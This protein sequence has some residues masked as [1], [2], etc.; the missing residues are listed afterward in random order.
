[1]NVS[2]RGEEGIISKVITNGEGVPIA[3]TAKVCQSGSHKRSGTGV[4]LWRSVTLIFAIVWLAIVIVPVYYMVLT[5]LRSQGTYLT[6]DPW[7]PSGHLSLHE[8]FVVLRAGL[9]RYFLNSVLVTAGAIILTVAVGLG[10][11]FRIV[12]SRS[13]AGRRSFTLLLLGLAVPL[14]AAVV[15]LYLL[16]DKLGL[17]NTL[18]ALILA[19]AAAAL[20]V[21][22][23]IL[24]SFIR[25]IPRETIAAME[26]DGGSEGTVFR[27][28][29]IPLSLP[30]LG[31][32][33]IYDGINVWNNFLL[34][35]ILTQGGNVGVLPLGLYKFEG[36]YTI[37]VP[38]VMAA[39]LLSVLPL[40]LLYLVLRRQVVRSLSGLGGIVQR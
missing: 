1:M 22:V 34:P 35:L 37:D 32:V 16:I 18:W 33:S 10:G 36:T 23:L 17:Y 5:S 6:A 24:V 14:Q 28:L 26:V 12:R 27:Y 4:S 9:G 8:Y 19:M 29:I 2:A 21:S 13:S 11:A 7:L 20:P 15:P 39:V 40:V 25:D 30:V 31:T 38:A 3:R